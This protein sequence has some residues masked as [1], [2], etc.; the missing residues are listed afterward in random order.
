MN[1]NYVQGFA[2]KCAEAGVDP[3]ELGKF[4][5]GLAQALPP[6]KTGPAG[7][8][9]MAAAPTGAEQGAFKAK[10]QAKRAPPAAAPEPEGSANNVQPFTAWPS[11]SALS[12]EL[13]QFDRNLVKKQRRMSAAGGH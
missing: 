13:V 10:V 9:L 5:Q 11:P 4:A 2:Q 1:K 6:P 7:G 3:A 12:N 8:Q